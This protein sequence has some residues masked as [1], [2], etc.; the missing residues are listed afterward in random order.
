MILGG[1]KPD[2]KHSKDDITLLKIYHHNLIIE[3][4]KMYPYRNFV[5][6]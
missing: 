1:M 2:R 4:S 5:V 3:T 6:L